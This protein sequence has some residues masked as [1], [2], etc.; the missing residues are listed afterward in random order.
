MGT[1]RLI[2]YVDG[3]NLYYGLRDAR[4]RS[5]RWLD[6]HGVCTSLLKLSQRLEL[7]RYFTTRVRGDPAAV[8]RQSVYIDALLARGGLEIDFG[9]FLSSNTQCRSCGAVTRKREEKKTDVNIA[10]R[11]LEDAYSD[12]FDVAMVISGDSDL[13]PPVESVRN[14]FPDKRVLVAAP[15]ER[16]SAQLSQAAN[17]ALRISP[18]TI[19]SNR[20]PDPVVTP[21]GTQLWAPRGWLPHWTATSNSGC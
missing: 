5:S 11:L 6:L 4:L 16:W 8:R 19:R 20:L 9:H 10:V 21:S 3:F 15:P 14:R 2:A 1:D 13:V 7:V 12:R 18:L 17:A